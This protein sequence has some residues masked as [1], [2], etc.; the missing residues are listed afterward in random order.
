M[1]KAMTG[2]KRSRGG[3]GSTIAAFL[4][5][6]PM[7][8]GVVWLFLHGPLRDHF[9]HR[10]VAFPVMWVEVS[11]F[12]CGIGA[13]IVKW[14]GIQRDLLACRRQILPEWDGQPSSPDSAKEMLEQL[15]Q[16]PRRVQRSRIFARF[17]AVLEFVTLRR[18]AQQ[19]DDHLH[20]LSDQE[21][22]DQ[23]NSGGLIRFITWAIPILG[24]L[25]TVIGITGAIG[26]VTP[27][28]LEESLS[29]VTDGLAEAFDSTALALGLT[30]VLMFLSYLV[31]KKEQALLSR[32]D[33][34]TEAELGHRFQREGQE[35]TPFLNIVRESTSALA[36]SVENLVKRQ[37]QLWADAL[38]EPKRRLVQSY[39]QAEEHM[40]RAMTQAMKETMEA[41][42]HRLR[43]MEQESLQRQAGMVQEM[44]SLA[45]AI[46]ETGAQQ[47]ESLR[48]VAE[49]IQG[50]ASV[51][52]QLQADATNLVHLQAVMHQNLAALASASSFEEAVHSL[53][54]AVH[55]LTSRVSQPQP[56]R[57]HQGKAA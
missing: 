12:T 1:N 34:M 56:L 21:A 53:T 31:E 40:T 15:D 55:L 20:S 51:L 42:T 44:M 33:M 48:Q 26:G 3:M 43:E 27:E 10:Y 54:A 14:L 47:Q 32:I 19:L 46:R 2:S 24:F 49:G 37:T 11:F 18:S 50:Q 57:I 45:Q 52:G 36:A 39:Q 35:S 8:A 29:T 30:M 17:R 16:Q 13:I 25:G 28:V 9:L 23:E 38:D 5:G 6:L 4:L 7:A 41:H 22:L